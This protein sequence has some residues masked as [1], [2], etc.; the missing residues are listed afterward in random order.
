MNDVYGAFVNIEKTPLQS[1]KFTMSIVFSNNESEPFS[2]LI[3]EKRS[4]LSN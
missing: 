1:G 4:R 3:S 2:G